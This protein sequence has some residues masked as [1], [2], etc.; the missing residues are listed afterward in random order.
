VYVWVP[1][2]SGMQR[3]LFRSWRAA[4]TVPRPRDLDS[5]SMQIFP[6]IE[7][8]RRRG[9]EETGGTGGTKVTDV[10]PHLATDSLSLRHIAVWPRQRGSCQGAWLKMR[11]VLRGRQRGLLLAHRR[12]R[13]ALR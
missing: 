1:K 9:I 11:G 7:E 3:S 10:R 8:N 2:G 5:A 12:P 6:G 13:G 4:R